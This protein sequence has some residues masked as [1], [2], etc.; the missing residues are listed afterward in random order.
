MRKIVTL[1]Q[2]ISDRQIAIIGVVVGIL[3]IVLSI[4]FYTIPF[5][6]LRSWIGGM[7]DHLPFMILLAT[8]IYLLVKNINLQRGQLS[9]KGL[10]EL[11]ERGIKACKEAGLLEK[12]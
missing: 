6:E 8:S 9:A 7:Y 1:L 12:D 5:M 3:G 11:R 4:I 2:R 10:K